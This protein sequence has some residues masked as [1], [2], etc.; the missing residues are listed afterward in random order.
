MEWT[1]TI[2]REN[3]LEILASVAC[4]ACGIVGRYILFEELGNNGIGIR[5][6]GCSKHH[7]FI[8]QRVMW[9]RGNERRRSNDIV[10]VAQECGAY[11]YGCGL[12]FPELD[13]LGIALHVHHTRPF[14]D[15]GEQYKKIPLCSDCHEAANLMQRLHRRLLKREGG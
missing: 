1:S 5:C 11:C 3:A 14:A 9:L 7:P 10:A 4:P 6:D 12:T 8:K 2:T 13:K 15:H